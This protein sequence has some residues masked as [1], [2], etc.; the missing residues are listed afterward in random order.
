MATIEALQKKATKAAKRCLKRPSDEN[1]AALKKALGELKSAMRERR[2]PED[3]V[4]RRLVR[5]WDAVV[6]QFTV[7][8]LILP[9]PTKARKLVARF[10]K[11]VQKTGA[12]K[13]RTKSSRGKRRG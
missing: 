7:L 1:V 12:M 2:S 5:F 4:L 6:N 10:V 11:S 13:K 9:S 3:Q 8:P